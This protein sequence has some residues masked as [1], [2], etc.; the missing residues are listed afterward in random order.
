MATIFYEHDANPSALKGKTI[1]MPKL[2]T[3]VT[4]A[5]TSLLG[6]IRNA[7]AP[8]R[9]RR[10]ALRC[11]LPQKRPNAPITCRS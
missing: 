7:E 6:W 11:L 2:K 9:R 10:T 5:T 3:C 1:A 4:A 8:N